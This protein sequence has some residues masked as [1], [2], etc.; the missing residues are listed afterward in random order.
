MVE[1]KMCITVGDNELM[2]R[3]DPTLH[4][5]IVGR[6]GCRPMV[7]KE[8]IYKG[9]IYINE[10]EIIAKNDFEYFIRLALD[11]NNKLKVSEK[12]K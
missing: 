2:C 9:Y 11:F 3:I 5:S 7:M 1:G 8:R 4:D 12:T 6:K 10:A